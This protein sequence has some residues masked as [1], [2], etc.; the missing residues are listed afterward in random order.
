MKYFVLLVLSMLMGFVAGC[1]KG[2]PVGCGDRMDKIPNLANTVG[3]SLVVHC[4][5][6]C[7]QGVVYGDGIYT[8]DSSVCVAAVHAGVVNAVKGGNVKVE[9]VSSQ[10]GYAGSEKNGISTRA[11]S[12][13]WG[14]TA[15]TVK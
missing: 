11:W 1:K 14:N 5:Q 6:N 2:Q 10:P 15:F 4:P 13:S 7:F 12:S 9:V 8:V 3:A